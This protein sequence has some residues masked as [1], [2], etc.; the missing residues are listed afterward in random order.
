MFRKC[1]S[2]TW[3]NQIFTLI[4]SSAF[5]STTF[6]LSI[7]FSVVNYTFSIKTFIHPNLAVKNRTEERSGGE[8]GGEVCGKC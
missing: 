1:F 4:L 6:Y 3:Q 7:L 5:V 2:A 8:R